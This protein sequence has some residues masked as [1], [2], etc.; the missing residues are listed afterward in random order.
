MCPRQFQ[1]AE[2][3]GGGGG[4]S[5]HRSWHSCMGLPW[6]FHGAS[7]EGGELLSLEG[8]TL[9]LETVPASRSLGKGLKVRMW[10]YFI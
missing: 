3:A 8:F 10:Q 7:E 5:G 1:G 6:G 9:R 4:G 2:T